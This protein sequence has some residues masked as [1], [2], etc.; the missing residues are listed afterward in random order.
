MSSIGPESGYDDEIDLFE[1]FQ[2]VWTG[3]WLI[4]LGSIL[5]AALS[6]WISLQLPNVYTVEIKIAAV[7]DDQNSQMNGLVAQ[8]GGLAS[9]AGIPIPGGGGGQTDLLLEILQSRSFLSKF[10]AETNIGPRL[11]AMK[12]FD[13][14][15]GK[16]TM[17]PTLFDEASGQWVREVVL[18]QLP[19]PSEQ[20]YYEAF[21]NAL[22]VNKDK[23]SPLIIIAFEHQ[24]PK[25]GYDILRQLVK[26]IDDF[27]RARDKTKSEQS[28]Q[29]L[30]Q[31][32]SQT[33]LVDVEK[34]LYQMI[35]AQTKTLMLAEVNQD[36]AFQVI[37]A[38]VVPEKR[39]KPNR[40]LIVVLSTL[41]GGML[42]VLWVLIRSAVQKR[43]LRAVSD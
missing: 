38:P 19:E 8:Y 28:I 14:I 3:K 20:E 21:T 2:T 1:L 6:A 40:A 18:P 7:E 33:R 23:T 22:T 39:S 27:A 31:K 9:L 42:M 13:P 16:E 24:S 36:Y 34:V 26:R 15:S 25:L 43:R 37:D 10:V 12:Q 32:L 5:A 17:D 4:I 35:E 41:V 11:V 29:Y 30:E